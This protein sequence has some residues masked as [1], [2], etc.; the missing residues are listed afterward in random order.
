MP[1]NYGSGERGD[2][3]ISSNTTFTALRSYRNL[4]INSGVTVTVPNGAII[5][6]SDTL[7]L[8]GTINVSHRVGSGAGVGGDAGGAVFI[9]AKNVTG[10]GQINA[11]GAN[12]GNR[13]NYG[14]SNNRNY[15]SSGLPP[16][17][18]G[19]SDNVINSGSDGGG[20]AGGEGGGH[21][22][23]P[24]PSAMERD[25]L[26]IW[27][28]EWI[29]PSAS[30]STFPMAKILSAG[31]GTG[32]KGGS[33]GNNNDNQGGGGGGGGAGGSLGGRGGSGGSG[34]NTYAGNYSGYDGGG[35]GGAGGLVVIIS[36]NPGQNITAD[37]SGGDG[38][39]GGSSSNSSTG[40]SGGGGGG[41][42]VISLTPDG[43]TPD[44]NLSG[45]ASGNSRGGQNGEDGVLAY[46]P[47]E[48][49]K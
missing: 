34:G 37:V 1:I 36:E 41:G 24:G 39:N 11:T 30:I 28:D 13:N 42:I 44:T 26:S 43:V 20:N 31:G 35:G 19:R 12:G 4:T 16:A 23:N 10:S 8:D 3:T 22:G 46:L 15:A 5:Q 38:G 25:L 47:V 32:G 27:L 21:G 7:K 45:G 14:N 29:M 48:L 6:V 18:A 49:I 33:S 40:G 2:V 9:A 17:L